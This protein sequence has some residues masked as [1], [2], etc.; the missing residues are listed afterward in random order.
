MK[1]RDI[2]AAPAADDAASL[3]RQAT[4]RSADAMR[5]GRY[6][7]ARNLAALADSYERM[8][9]RRQTAAAAEDEPQDAAA[10]QALREDLLRRLDALAA[11]IQAR[12]A[13]EAAAAFSPD[14][15]PA[16]SGA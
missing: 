14:A 2:P 12:Q 9:A 4:A 1:F 6:A 11:E 16:I 3:A 15:E 13:E 8:A 10:E 5:E 7:D